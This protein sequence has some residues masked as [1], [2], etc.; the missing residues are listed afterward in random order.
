MV[1]SSTPPP[2]TSDQLR[3]V[4]QLGIPLEALDGLAALAP[5]GE[6]FAEMAALRDRYETMIG[7]A[8]T[9]HDVLPHAGGA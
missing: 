5:L 6:H 9:H 3:A 4:M 7:E 8:A 2:S 1:T